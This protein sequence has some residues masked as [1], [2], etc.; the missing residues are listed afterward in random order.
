MNIPSL[1]EFVRWSVVSEEPETTIGGEEGR[2]NE[3]AIKSTTQSTTTRQM[4]QTAEIRTE[5]PRKNNNYKS[6]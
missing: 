5:G 3:W 4:P 1:V 6:E 2:A